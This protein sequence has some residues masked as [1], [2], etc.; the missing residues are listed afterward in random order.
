MTKLLCSALSL[1]THRQ[2]SR[3]K[4]STPSSKTLQRRSNE[5]FWLISQAVGMCL[6]IS[7]LWHVR[8]QFIWRWKH[9]QSQHVSPDREWRKRLNEN[10]LLLFFHPGRQQKQNKA[11]FT[12]IHFL[13]LSRNNNVKIFLAKNCCLVVIIFQSR[14]KRSDSVSFQF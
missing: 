9:R 3:R 1:S 12:R 8:Q 10:F 5:R 2:E 13:G 7:N 14:P 11:V 6:F 4:I